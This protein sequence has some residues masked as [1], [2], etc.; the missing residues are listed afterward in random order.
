MGGTRRPT[1]SCSGSRAEAPATCPSSIPTTRRSCARRH[2]GPDRRRLRAARRGARDAA[3]SSCAASCVSLACKYRWCSSGSRRVSGPRGAAHPRDRRRRAQRLLCRLTADV[4]RPRGARRPGRGHR[5]R[6]CARPGPRAG[7]LARSPTCAR[8]PPPPAP[9]AYEPDGDRAR[10]DDL[11]LPGR[12]RPSAA[13]AMTHRRW[14][15]D[16]STR[17]RLRALVIETPSWG[18]GNSGTRFGVFPQPGARGTRREAR[19]RRRGP[20][21]DRHAPAR[22]RCT[23]RGTRSTTTARCARTSGAR[24]A[25]RRDQ[26]EPLP[27]AGLQARLDLPSRRAPSAEGGRTTCSSASR[28]PT[29]SARRAVALAR[30]RHELSRPGRP[31]RRRRAAARVARRGSTRQLPAEKELLVEY[32][33]YEP[34]FYATDL[35][36]WGSRCSLPGARRPR[37]G[38]R[39]PRPPRA[40]RRTSSRSSRCSAPSRLGG[41]HFNNRKY[42]DDDLIVGSIDP[43]QLFRIFFE[44]AERRAAV[45]LTIDQSHNIE[46]K[47]EAMIQTRD[48]PAGGVCKGAARRPRRAGAAQPAATCSA[49]TACCST[50]SDRCAPAVREGARRARRRG[51]SDRRV[52]HVGLRRARRRRATRARTTG[53]CR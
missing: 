26:P 12:H 29:S 15:R 47:I 36:D 2:A 5:A 42:G 20:P 34:A 45:R 16:D 8:S 24:P 6:Q 31:A 21:A 32:K 52:P 38:A 27:G 7:E 53:A 35:A 14:R 51:G 37:E 49:A 18:F 3:A 43:F 11:A 22:S 50:P 4:T 30:R 10:W 1:T 23:S 40:G 28:S 19:G 9:D 41:F 46:P 44:L 48:E 13:T 17:E 39:R 33:L 25:S